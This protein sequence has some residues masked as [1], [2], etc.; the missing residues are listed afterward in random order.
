VGLQDVPFAYQTLGWRTAVRGDAAAL[1]AFE[2]YAVPASIK[3]SD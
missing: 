3:G 1:A 2:G